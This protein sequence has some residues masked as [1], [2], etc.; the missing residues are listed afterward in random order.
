MEKNKVTVLECVLGM[1]WYPW[2][3]YTSYYLLLIFIQLTAK[4]YC[5]WLALFWNKHNSEEV[6]WYTGTNKDIPTN[7]G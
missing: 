7:K 1:I 4:V 3:L 5:L 2:I 6:L